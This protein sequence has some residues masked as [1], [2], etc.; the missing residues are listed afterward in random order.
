MR[1]IES[2]AL[3][4]D[5]EWIAYCVSQFDLRNNS[6]NTD[7]Y[8]VNSM[9]GDS[10]Q[11]TTHPAYDGNP[12]WS[13]DGTLLSFISTRSGT[14]QIYAIPLHGGEA[15]RITD[16]PIGVK[17]FIWSP[18][19]M[20]FVFSTDVF[21]S[22]PDSSLE[23]KDSDPF[24]RSQARVIDKL[25]YRHWNRWLDGKRSHLFAMSSSGGPAWD[26]T[27]GDY[28]TPPVSLGSHCDFAFSP[29]GREIAFVRNIDP[30]IESS[31][32]ND[33]FVVPIKGGK[34]RR[35]TLN[36]AND[37]YP[38]YSP[39]G[40][41]IAYRTMRR[42]GFGADQYDLMLLNRNDSYLRNATAEFD[43]DVD[44]IVWSSNSDKL[45]FTSQDNGR[46]VLISLDIKKQKIK[47]IM[48][49][50]C[51]SNL[52]VSPETDQLYF[53]RTQINLPHEIF[54][55]DDEGERCHRLTFENEKLLDRLEMNSVIDF[56][57]PSYDGEIV[58]GF[59]LKPPFFNPAKTYPAIC[60]IH[61]GPQETWE[62]AFH[63][64][65][66]AQM[67]ASRGN[68][69]IMINVR[70]SKG[71][72]QVF[73]DG[74][75]RNW[76][77][78]PFRDITTGLDFILKKYSF[79]DPE[80]LSAAGASFGGY[81]INWIAGH[82]DRFRCLISHD[83]IAN[84]V[85]FYGTT[86]ELWFPEWEFDG[87]PYENSKLYEKWSPLK[88]AKNFKTPTL[89]VHGEQDF[90]IPVEQGLQMFT[91]LKKQNVP[92]RFLYFPDEGHLVTKPQNAKIWWET[93]LNWI[94]Q[95]TQQRI[96]AQ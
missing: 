78:P 20:Y 60:L 1:K 94:D 68:A 55:C 46:I 2:F 80:R 25:F 59:L 69:V 63:Y 39:D 24:P 7:I 19:G 33:I 49:T 45:Y 42:P 54:G 48:H 23:I 40:K 34:I 22:A 70:G 27:P 17:Q 16:I 13:P 85:S 92:S 87:N 6:N 3:S 21:P 83:G 5:G 96:P 8:L 10:R 93:V 75:S 31:T 30:S 82:T 18:D 95:W 76:G 79:I 50:A 32:N 88:Y 66:N 65:W 64:R 86:E 47:V 36:L 4:P 28:D 61:G 41:Y 44:E 74:V 72:G 15:Q 81:L 77:G 12:C 84:P 9:G 58:H 14:R 51:N 11:L 71:Y 67:F 35:I 90:R 38:V 43:L 89:V 62:D 56:W 57:F 26:L 52:V 53:L 91:A 37:N 29:D 73:S